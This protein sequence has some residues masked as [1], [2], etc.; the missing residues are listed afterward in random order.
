MR[1]ANIDP[2]TGFRFVAAMM[3]FISHYAIPGLTGTPLRMTQSGYSGVTLFFVLSGFIIAYSYLDQFERERS[4]AAIRDFLVARFA[5]IYPLYFFFILFGY[6]ISGADSAP[7]AH[8]LAVQTWSPDSDLA[9]SVNGPSWSIGV[10][11]FFYLVFPLLIPVLTRLG[12][13][14]SLRRLQLAAA[15]VALAMVAAAAWFSWKGLNDLPFEDPASAYRWL[16]RTPVMRMGDFLLGI[17]AAVYYMRFARMDAA[18]VRRWGHVT[19]G[20]VVFLL[21]LLAARKNFRSAFSWDVAYALP[22]VLLIVGLAINRT[23]WASRLLASAPLLLLGE[24]SYA[25]YL[26]HVP[27]KPMLPSIPLGG[28]GHQ[29]AVYGL[30]VAWVIAFSIGLH[31]ALEKPARKWIRGRFSSGVKVP[32]PNLAPAP[33]QQV[34]APD[35]PSPRPFASPIRARFW[36]AS[37][38][39]ARPRRWPS[40]K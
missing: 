15:V 12:V 4:V 19:L 14:A 7:W 16:W 29:L 32:A 5:R 18:S 6:V 31:I 20:C 26:A 24:A 3:V 40:S 17:L 33:E 21:L 27:A 28:T 2:L 1:R 8:L 25:L 34:M 37:R 38:A 10:E 23:T 30:F 35:G 13:L 36:P 22:G 9:F 39:R 11:V